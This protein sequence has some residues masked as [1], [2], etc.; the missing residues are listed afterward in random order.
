MICVQCKNEKWDQ[1]IC[2]QCGLGEK[3]ALLKRA[4]G[5]RNDR[6]YSQAVDYYNKVL[7]RDPD[8]TDVLKQKANC[9]YSEAVSLREKLLFEK[10]EELLSSILKNDWSWEKG[11]QL[12]IDLFY[13]FGQLDKLSKEYLEISDREGPRQKIAREAL[14]VIQ[15][16]TRFNEN[17]PNV[18]TELSSNTEWLLL[19]KSFWLLFLGIPGL[20]WL[21]YKLTVAPHARE[22]SNAPG[23]FFVLMIIITTIILIIY[24]SMKMY[25]RN[26]TKVKEGNRIEEADQGKIR[27]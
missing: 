20:L 2:S 9:I 3:E 18:L 26:Q 19:L 14:K 10:A 5:Y 8:D 21:V 27:S 12:R 25:K 22:E 24:T 23:L 16:T 4:N 7:S 6:N 15:L 17:P 13:C 1:D 11:H